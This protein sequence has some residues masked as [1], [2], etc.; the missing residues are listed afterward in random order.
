M[1][2]QAIG[3][4]ARPGIGLWLE[5]VVLYA[6]LPM[7]ILYSRLLVVLLAVLWI[8]ALGIHLFLKHRHAMPHSEDWNMAGFR[9]GASSVMLRFAVLATLVTVSVW[10]FA[11]DMFLSFPR[12]RPGFWLVVMVLYPVLSV[13]PQELVYRSFLYYRYR[14][15]FGEQWGYVLASSLAFGYVHV[16]FLNWIAPAMT[17]VGGAL[18]AMS[19][20][21]HKSLALSCFEHALYGCLI[22]TLGLGQFF[23]TGAAWRH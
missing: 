6:G 14:P 4:N 22:F 5:F 8:G 21:R 2:R 3:S 18:F 12:Q 13:W 17:L 23:Y 10:Y 9:A 11:P 19:Y 7:L 1:N 20:R 15:I 16:I